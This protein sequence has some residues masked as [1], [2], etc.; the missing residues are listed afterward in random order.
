MFKSL[1]I[2]LN[3]VGLILLPFIYVGE[4]SVIHEL[5]SEIAEGKSV[6]V[7]IIINK[8]SATGPARLALNIENA[9]GILIEEVSNA[10]ASFS[11][12]N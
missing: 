7:A 3:L 4:I 5:P 10:G 8:G 12:D 9:P 6:E 11:F 2:T 1:F